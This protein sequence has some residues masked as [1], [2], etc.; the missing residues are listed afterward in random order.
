MA[1]KRRVRSTV[2]RRAE[3]KE[4][5]AFGMKDSGV[6]QQFDTGAVRDTA[7]GKGRYDLLSP[8]ALY[9]LAIIM[10]RGAAKYTPRNWEKGMSLSRYL[11]SA[12]RH[13]VQ[14]LDGLD[15]EDHAAQAAFNI[16][17]FIHTEHRVRTGQLPSE[18][19]DLP[20][21][22]NLAVGPEK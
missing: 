17:A 15:D 1:R 16:F 11:D 13:L 5:Y 9:R 7:Q 2:R 18:L 6:R 4:P 14:L 12:I 19:D 20:H 10:E 3:D 22:K 8:I 21:E